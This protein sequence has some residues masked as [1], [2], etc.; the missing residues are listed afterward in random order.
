MKKTLTYQ[1]LAAALAEIN[2]FQ[3][4]FPAISTLFMDNDLNGFKRKNKVYIDLL[5]EKVSKIT[6]DFVVQENGAPKI[7][8]GK[9]AFE[10]EEKEKGYTDAINK[11]YGTQITIVT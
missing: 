3:N 1:D 10:N 6:S 5:T 11:L 8:D 9:Y 2:R 7:V 4:E